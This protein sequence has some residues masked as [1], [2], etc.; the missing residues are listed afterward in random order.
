MAMSFKA[1]NFSLRWPGSF[2]LG[3]PFALE[4]QGMPL[5]PCAAACM[6]AKAIVWLLFKAHPT[7]Q[8]CF[9]GCVYPTPFDKDF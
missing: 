8:R 3:I 1:L 5:V 9:L 7:G 4:A 2:T 6:C